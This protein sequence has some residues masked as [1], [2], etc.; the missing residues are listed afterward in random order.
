MTGLQQSETRAL[1]G[2]VR[3]RLWLQCAVDAGSRDVRLAGAVLLI[4]GLYHL[5]VHAIHAG[6]VVALAVL[7]LVMGLVVVLFRRRPGSAA[8][9]RT[10]DIWFDGKNLITSA[11]ELLQRRSDHSSTDELVVA[12]AQAVAAQWRRQLAS[13]QPLRWPQRVT[14]PLLLALTGLLL[15]QLPSKEWLTRFKGVENVQIGE[16]TRDATPRDSEHNMEGQPSQTL[17]AARADQDALTAMASASL[18]S[19]DAAA[20]ATP[21]QASEGGE[22]TEGTQGQHPANKTKGAALSA[23][24]P[25]NASS[26]AAA[27]GGKQ[28][29]NQGGIRVNRDIRIE[30]PPLA[31]SEVEI[32]RAAGTRGNASNGN[33]LGDIQGPRAQASSDAAIVPAAR[34]AETAYRGDYTPGLRAYM[35]RYF[36]ELNTRVSQP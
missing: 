28:P 3:D 29:G 7:P 12:R 11:W 30:A 21:Q 18:H 1:I 27:A 6:P 24:P 31:V 8:A 9:A 35:A 15:L 36:L 20:T 19:Q 4:G 25:E 13:V 32:Q 14:T 17:V 23:M 33:E 2:A 5:F 22:Q 34:H 16:R 26:A 10:A